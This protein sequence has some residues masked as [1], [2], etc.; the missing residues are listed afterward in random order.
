MSQTGPIAVRLVSA[1]AMTKADVHAQNQVFDKKAV[2]GRPPLSE[3]LWL[4][5]IEGLTD[6][7]TQPLGE[8]AL[9]DVF[10]TVASAKWRCLDSVQSV[11][12]NRGN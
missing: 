1:D 11:R 4:D 12:L 8:H 5:F 9:D 7:V 3:E 6:L 2:V 10:C